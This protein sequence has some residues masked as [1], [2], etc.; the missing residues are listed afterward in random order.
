MKRSTAPRLLIVSYHAPPSAAVGGLRWW[1]LGKYLARAGWEV[2]VLTSGDPNETAAPDGVRVVRVPRK[3]TLQD[4]YRTWR[5]QGNVEVKAKTA[6]V[7]ATAIRGTEAAAPAESTW[8]LFREEISE[9]LNFPDEARGW[10][11]RALVA[12]RDLVREFAPD[13]IVS[14]GPPHSMHGLARMLGAGPNV[15]YVMDYRDPWYGHQPTSRVG[16]HILGWQ[17]NRLVPTAH[18]VLG[19]TTQLVDLLAARFPAAPLH[20][21]PNGVDPESLPP[22]RA[23]EAGRREVLHLGSLYIQRDPTPVIAA[24]RRLRER[25][26]PGADAIVL[27][28]IGQIEEPHRSVV[29]AAA[30]EPLLKDHLLV[31]PPMPRARALDALAGCGLSLVLA[32]AQRD[33][34]PAKLFES[35][36]MR[37]PTLVITER[38]S[39]TAA[40]CDRIG[41][42]RCEAQ[43]LEAIGRAL[44]GEGVRIPGDVGSGMAVTH[45]GL[46]AVAAPLLLGAPT[47]R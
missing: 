28:F 6:A 40:A 11:L 26:V 36:G 3:H 25:D 20:W 15:R 43:D 46:A 7:H 34:V 45:E 14:T 19:T 38:D 41:V 21:L 10:L 1:G 37:V 27:R 42:T 16:R 8:Q 31:E 35:V 32:Q 22:R 9:A 18:A 47:T 2:V 4:R 30:A 44:L 17:E 33:L 29:A 39:A 12:G 24:L 5:A 23:P 13:V